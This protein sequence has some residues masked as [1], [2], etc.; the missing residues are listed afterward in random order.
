MRFA[1]LTFT[2]NVLGTGYFQ[3]F[4]RRCHCSPYHVIYALRVE[5]NSQEAKES[6]T[7]AIAMTAIVMSTNAA[8]TVAAEVA[9]DQT[10]LT[11]SSA[12]R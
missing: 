11:N 9:G 5:S 1:C 3:Y 2:T 10:T 6:M 7:C 12:R 8:Y 4:R